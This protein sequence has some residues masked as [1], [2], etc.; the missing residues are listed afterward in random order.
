MTK[1]GPRGQEGS[2]GQRGATPR[3]S[4][5]RGLEEEGRADR[6]PA[7]TEARS[8]G[9]SEREAGRG[10]AGDEGPEVAEDTCE[11]LQPR[12]LPGQPH[13]GLPGGRPWARRGRASERLMGLVCA[14]GGSARCAEG[15]SGQ[16]QE[17]RSFGGFDLPRGG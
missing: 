11:P 9:L 3:T 1:A 10:V 14:R 8:S 15:R 7:W 6:G 17:G 2:G 12:A 16:T 5:G 4:R 13:G